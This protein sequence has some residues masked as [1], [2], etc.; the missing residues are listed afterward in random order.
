MLQQDA[1][2][3]LE[4]EP[5][6]NAAHFAVGHT[7]RAFRRRQLGNRKLTA[8]SALQVHRM[9]PVPGTFHIMRHPTREKP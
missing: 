3:E 9:L 6:V 4:G 8:Y 5:S 7:G 1:M 2:A